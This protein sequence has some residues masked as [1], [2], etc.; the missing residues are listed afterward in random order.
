MFKGDDHTVREITQEHVGKYFAKYVPQNG[1][2]PFTIHAILG[3]NSDDT[4]I[5]Q[6]EDPETREVQSRGKAGSVKG[7]LWQP[8][9]HDSNYEEFRQSSPHSKEDEI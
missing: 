2:K 6:V 1:G 4:Y 9:E 3:I 8:L 7:F 5:A